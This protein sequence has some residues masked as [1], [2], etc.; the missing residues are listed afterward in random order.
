MTKQPYTLSECL[1]PYRAA[2][3]KAGTHEEQHRLRLDIHLALD[4]ANALRA[5]KAASAQST[6][7]LRRVYYSR[8][9]QAVLE[10]L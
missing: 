6:Q 1:E 4:T 7:E 9:V 10:K 2:T 3:L 8:E 5:L